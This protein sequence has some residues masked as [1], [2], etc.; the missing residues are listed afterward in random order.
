MVDLLLGLMHAWG[1]LAHKWK[2][3][4]LLLLFRAPFNDEQQV[5]NLK[6]MILISMIPLFFLFLP[7]V[8]LPTAPFQFLCTVSFTSASLCNTSEH[9]SNHNLATLCKMLFII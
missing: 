1:V 7:C 3:R 8:I 4:P 5:H 2:S 6:L 9:M